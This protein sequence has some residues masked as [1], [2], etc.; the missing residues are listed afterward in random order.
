[1]LMPVSVKDM[2][3]P[4]HESEEYTKIIPGLKETRKRYNFD[5]QCISFL[6]LYTLNRTISGLRY[7]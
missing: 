2:V 6:V 4:G 1:V 5:A 3:N 7:S